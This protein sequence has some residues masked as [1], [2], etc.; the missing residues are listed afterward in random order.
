MSA[1]FKKNIF[2]RGQA[3][4]ELIIFLPI[5]ISLFSVVGGYA[6]AINGSINQ[7]KITRAYFYL[8]IQNN[9]T[10]PGPSASSEEA[11]ANWK[12]FGMFFIGWKDYFINQSSPVMPCYKVTIPFKNSNLSSCEEAYSNQQTQFVRVGTVY[13]LCGATYINVNGKVRQA[14]PG[15]SV[16]FS[17]CLIR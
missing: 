5:I 2:S 1:Q 17:S 12:K 14:D 7:Q 15:Q 4:I 3:L 16:D 10:I 9:S 6:T 11:M 13:G 8:R